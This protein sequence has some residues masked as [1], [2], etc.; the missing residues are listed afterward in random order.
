MWPFKKK[1]PTSVATPLQQMSFS[2]LD[3]TEGF[4]DD[5]SLGPDDWV[6]TVALNA[7]VPDPTSHGLP[8]VDAAPEEVFRVADRLSTLRESIP[9]QGDGVYCPICHK[10]NMLLTR[11]RKPCP[12]CGRPLLKFGWD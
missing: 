11:L 3:V 1:Q 8:A 2:Q 4:G 9:I 5:R 12:S 7:S 6:D 10:A